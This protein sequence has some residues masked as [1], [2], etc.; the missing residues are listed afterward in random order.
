MK[1]IFLLLIIFL[2]TGCTNQ[3]ALEK[4]YYK[5]INDVNECDYFA[6]ESYPFDINITLKKLNDEYLI[7]HVYIDNPKEDLYDIK[8]LITHNYKT[9]DIFPSSG[10]YE[11]PLDLLMQ[12]DNKDYVKGIILS[13][14]IETDKNIED[15]DITF[16]ALIKVKNKLGYYEEFCYMKSFNK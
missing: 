16:K 11:E 13:G 10:L 2:I 6:N 5:Y 14:Y 8:A 9:S 7:Y 3:K 15:I 4:Q 1:K 12:E